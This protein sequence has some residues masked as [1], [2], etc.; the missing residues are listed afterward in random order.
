MVLRVRLAALRLSGTRTG[1]QAD[2]THSSYRDSGYEPGSE[3]EADSESASAL[4]GVS[5]DL[6]KLET[7]PYEVLYTGYT[8]AYEKDP[9]KVFT[10]I[11][12]EKKSVAHE[13]YHLSHGFCQ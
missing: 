9:T 4:P 10:D 3:P 2:L 13:A 5:W 12:F 1:A 6:R 11:H 8:V 7:Q